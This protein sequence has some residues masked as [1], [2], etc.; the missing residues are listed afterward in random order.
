LSGPHSEA[1]I[2]H[3]FGQGFGTYLGLGPSEGRTDLMGP[4]THTP[5]VAQ[6]PSAA[7]LTLVRQIQE[8]R[9]KLLDY[10]HR[11]VAVYLPKPVLAVEKR[12]E[13]AGDVWRGEKPHFTFV[14]KNAGDAPLEITAKPNCG[15]TVAHY[16]KVITPGA[17]GKIE[18]DVNTAAFRG[19]IQKQITVTSNDPQNPQVALHLAAN[20]KSILS[21]LPSEAPVIGLKDTGPTV[22]EFQIQVADKEPVEISRVTS[23]AAYATTKVEPL[24]SGA[25]G[26]QNYRLTV[27]IGPEAP[28]GRSVFLLTVQ[29]TSKREPTLNITAICDKGI[30][31]MPV[32]A[33]LGSIGPATTLPMNQIVTLQRREGTFNLKQIDTGDASLKVQQ[34][35][36]KEGQE[37]RLRLVY[38]G[39]WPAGIVQRKITVQTDDPRQP[40]IVIPVF[41]NV[42]A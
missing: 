20:V 35:T 7:D 27:T 10:A 9:A 42:Q 18:A 4:D 33:F 14:I 19:R 25:N 13:D 32:S 1:S 5:D 17:S 16:D 36:V 26:G 3:L 30:L 40:S 12:E 11:R 41:A 37:Y 38:N 34:E 29:T 31:A 2:A 8:A 39:G 6:Q 15:C 22:Q 21:V 24:P 28:M 23:S